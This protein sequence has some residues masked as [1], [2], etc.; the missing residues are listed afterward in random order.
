MSRI[1][2]DPKKASW[3]RYN[4]AIK[5]DNIYN[6]A[7]LE[8]HHASKG[9][10]KLSIAQIHERNREKMRQQNQPQQ[11]PTFLDRARA[12]TEPKKSGDVVCRKEITSIGDVRYKF[13]DFCY[14]SQEQ[15]E[16][17]KKDLNLTIVEGPEENEFSDGCRMTVANQTKV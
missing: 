14:L 13:S 8:I 17:L 3:T 16:Q 7:Y 4:Q 5:K 12:L 2:V 15:W 11:R 6:L 9:K 1:R 10:P